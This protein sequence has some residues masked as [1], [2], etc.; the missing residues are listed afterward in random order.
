M[1]RRPSST[2]TPD[3]VA[4]PRSAAGRRQGVL[5]TH[6][7]IHL[8]GVARRAQSGASDR[9]PPRSTCSASTAHTARARTPPRGG[10]TVTL[11]GIDFAV[12]LVPALAHV[13]RVLRDGHLFVG[14]V[15]FGARSV[16]P[17]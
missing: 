1:L 5:V 12:T 7:H 16:A 8:G 2:A 14:D 6:G 4:P 3:T 15:L 9:L 11:A 17:T 10:E 13:G